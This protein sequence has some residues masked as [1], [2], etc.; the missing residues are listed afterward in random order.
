MA[1]TRGS[2]ATIT[3]MKA[4][5]TVVGLALLSFIAGSVVT[6]FTMRMTQAA[7]PAPPTP[8]VPQTGT[9]LV[10]AGQPDVMVFVDGAIKG[11]TQSDGTVKLS[12]DPG[13]HSLRLVKE[14]YSDF[15]PPP[16]DIAV[17]QQVAVP[18]ELQSVSVASPEPTTNNA[19]PSRAPAPRPAP[20]SVPAP[21]AMFAVVPSTI[22]QG[23]SA[24]LAWQTLNA[25]GVSIDNGIGQV[26]ASGQKTV[27]PNSSATFTYVLTAK[28][29]GGTQ[30][31]SVSLIVTPR[32]PAPA[33]APKPKPVEESSL[34]Q[35]MLDK[36][37]AALA[38]RDVAGMQALGVS[39]REA[40][41]W[42]KFFTDNPEGKV[43][44]DCSPSS[45]SFLSGNTAR[46]SCTESIT[47]TT[48]GGESRTSTHEIQLMFTKRDGAWF[49]TSR[50]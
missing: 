11:L 50:R 25:N 27:T 21:L 20:K 10:Q 36:F 16:V 28:G 7:R 35:A 46:W 14:G 23:Q 4:K 17:N 47:F 29:A 22:E 18:A 9:L 45:L 2:S 19:P 26:S 32:K 42:A 39:S 41:D 13:S 44:D 6:I 40:R 3:R 48:A 43:V 12:L 24:V 34:V 49:I 30:Q 1:N 5:L 8:A 38:S 15:S 37:N 31:Q 33:P